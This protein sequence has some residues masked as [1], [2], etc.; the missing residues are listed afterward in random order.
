MAEPVASRA[1]KQ[2]PA[3][4]QSSTEKLFFR[5]FDYR[6]K[7]FDRLLQLRFGLGLGPV[8]PFIFRLAECRSELFDQRWCFRPYKGFNA[9][10]FVVASATVRQVQS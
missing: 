3:L 9:T 1:I 2:S 6:L 5:I 8:I 4:R 7:Y 10:V